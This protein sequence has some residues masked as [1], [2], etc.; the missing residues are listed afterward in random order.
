MMPFMQD[1]RFT[2]SSLGGASNSKISRQSHLNAHLLVHNQFNKITP[3]M[4]IPIQTLY[5]Q[6]TYLQTGPE[7]SKIYLEG[8]NIVMADLLLTSTK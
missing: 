5:I 1:M 3:S 2:K 4:W 7:N 6:H 8:G